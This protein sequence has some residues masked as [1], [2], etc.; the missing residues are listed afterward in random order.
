MHVTMVTH[1][2]I[3][4]VA[5]ARVGLVVDRPW[6]RT[7]IVVCAGGKSVNREKRHLVKT[8]LGLTQINGSTRMTTSVLTSVLYAPLT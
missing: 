5:G 8:K 1:I 6:V 4:V 7:I 2:M 3:C